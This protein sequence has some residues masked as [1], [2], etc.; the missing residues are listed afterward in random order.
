[1]HFHNVD[2]ANHGINQDIFRL[3]ACQSIRSKGHAQSSSISKPPER[4]IAAHWNARRGVT[5]LIQQWRASWNA[6]TLHLLALPPSMTQ[7]TCSASLKRVRRVSSP[8]SRQSSFPG[9]PNMPASRVLWQYITK[10][11]DV[12]SSFNQLLIIN[13]IIFLI[14]G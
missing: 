14:C 7:Q 3:P 8:A 9:Q 5:Y 11:L 12:A 4:R 6:P 13:S 1:M 2:P 10:E